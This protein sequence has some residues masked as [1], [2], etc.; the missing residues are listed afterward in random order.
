[1]EN[2]NLA[3]VATAN[4][5]LNRLLLEIQ[6]A[7][8]AYLLTQMEFQIATQTTNLALIRYQQAQVSLALEIALN[9][10]NSKP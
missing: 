8:A 2:T 10:E 9:G 3:E 7:Q 5:D 6:R 4:F 1:M